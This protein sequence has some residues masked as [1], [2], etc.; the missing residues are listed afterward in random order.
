MSTC[1]AI[2]FFLSVIK[3]YEATSGSWLLDRFRLRGEMKLLH[4]EC[5]KQCRVAALAFGIADTFRLA[6]HVDVSRRE[7][8][9]HA[10]VEA[11]VFDGVLNLAVFDVPDA[12]ARETCI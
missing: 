8:L 7:Q 4:F 1:I 12:V 10:L 9:D 2:P 6:D 5:G 11:E 3:N